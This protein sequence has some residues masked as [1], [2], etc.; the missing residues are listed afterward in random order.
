MEDKIHFQV[1]T[2]GGTVLD[3]MANYV[4]VPLI[5]GDAGILAN[6]APMLAS[7]KPGV[8][9]VKSEEGEQY[10]ALSGGVLSVSDNEL[11]ILARTAELA[12]S[13]D[14]ERAKDSEKRARERIESRSR[15]WDMSRAE[16]SLL[17]SLARQKAY[18][19]LT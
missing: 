15:E 18:S 8:A 2:A 9:K 7:I 3:R 12:E 4:N 10:I 14:L 11:V 5:D 6:H 17:R 19:Y 16:A 13:I 1:V